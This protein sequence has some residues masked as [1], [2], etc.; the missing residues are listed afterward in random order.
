MGW[1]TAFVAGYILGGMSGLVV[2]GMLFGT[3]KE[4]RAE[5][6]GEVAE[7]TVA[8]V[9]RATEGAAVAMKDLRAG[10]A[11]AEVKRANDAKWI[12]P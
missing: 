10:K 3:R 9:K 7:E 11:P 1:G 6:R 12:K 4:G 5:V 8:A 2:F